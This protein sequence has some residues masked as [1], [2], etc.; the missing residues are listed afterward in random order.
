MDKALLLLGIL[1]GV[2]GQSLGVGKLRASTVTRVVSCPV[3][4]HKRVKSVETPDWW[5]TEVPTA[6]GVTK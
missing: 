3:K 2:K 1:L 4:R 6:T 5:A